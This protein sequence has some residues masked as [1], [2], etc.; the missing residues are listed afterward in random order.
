MQ[1]ASVNAK[2]SKN[3]SILLVSNKTGEMLSIS[4]MLQRFEYETISANTVANALD[5]ISEAIPALAIVD[6]V[7]PGMSGMDLFHLLRQ[8]RRTAYLPVIFLIPM[9]DV[10]SERRC[11]DSGAAG[12]LS[13]PVQA[14]E[15]YQTVQTAMEL[16]PRANIR[17]VTKLA[18]SVDDA[19]NEA[20]EQRSVGLSERGMFVPT[21]GAFTR[22]QRV[23]VHM[24][25]KNRAISAEGTVIYRHVSGGGYAGETG[26]GLRFTDMDPLDRD[27][28]K[29]FI[30]DEIVRDIRT[31]ISRR[32]AFPS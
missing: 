17:I 9:S 21:T 26:I 8:D 27:F 23:T 13:M 20:E 18:V 5:R 3:R 15:L 1:D 28:I 14:E 11:L 6:L 2:K 16:R 29:A 22:N 24:H 19:P 31:V 32:E 10:A 4:L 7:L 30:R 12:C 25:I